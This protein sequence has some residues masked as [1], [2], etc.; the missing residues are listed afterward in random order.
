MDSLRQQECRV[1]NPDLVFAAIEGNLQK[2]MAIKEANCIDIYQHI[3]LKTYLDI[4][5]LITVCIRSFL[6][7]V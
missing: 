4:L 1:E 3:I 7:E 5:E 2:V 6:Q